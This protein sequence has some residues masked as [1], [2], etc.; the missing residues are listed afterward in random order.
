MSENNRLKE[1]LV[2]KAVVF[3]LLTAAAV[4]AVMFSA[5]PIVKHYVPFYKNTVELSSFCTEKAE[6]AQ[7]VSLP[8]QNSSVRKSDIPLPQSSS[9]IGS[10]NAKGNNLTLVYDADYYN[11]SKG[12]S[13]LAGTLPGETGTAYIYGYKCELPFLYNLEA[14]DEIT[15]SLFYG[16]YVF[17]V[18]GTDVVSGEAS[19]AS[20]NPGVKRGVVIYTNCNSGA[21][22]SNDYY[23]VTAELVSGAS[24]EG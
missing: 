21:G 2:K 13:L 7:A 8:V 19:V 14:G 20:Q 23:T 22:I 4:A 15:L 12:A 18:V 3:P 17:R 24:V 1:E 16:E 11:I 9:I 6:N 5:M 10:L